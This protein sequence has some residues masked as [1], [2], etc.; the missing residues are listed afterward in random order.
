LKDNTRLNKG[1]GSIER[2][3]CLFIGLAKMRGIGSALGGRRRGENESGASTGGAE[4]FP[5]GGVGQKTMGEKSVAF[6]FCVG[7]G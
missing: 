2:G 4:L 5:K 1:V 6:L 3:E 7:R